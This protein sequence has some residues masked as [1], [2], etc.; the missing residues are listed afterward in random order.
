MG[1]LTGILTLYGL[2]MGGWL[3]G[4]GVKSAVSTMSDTKPKLEPINLKA[5]KSASGRCNV[6]N[7]GYYAPMKKFV[8]DVVCPEIEGKAM[9]VADTLERLENRVADHFEYFERK[10]QKHHK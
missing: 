9:A 5:T 4:Q 6:E 3:A 8:A 7:Y 2:G 1:I 10:M